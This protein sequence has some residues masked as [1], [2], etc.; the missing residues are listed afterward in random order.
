[1]EKQLIITELKVSS[2]KLV[3]QFMTLCKYFSHRIFVLA[4]GL[5]LL[6][7]WSDFL[8]KIL[9]HLL[10]DSQSELVTKYPNVAFGIHTITLTIV[11]LCLF[12]IM[13]TLFGEDFYPDTRMQ[14]FS[15]YRYVGNENGA[16]VQ[17]V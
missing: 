3:N 8:S 5:I 10:V 15:S 13:T 16:D 14:P 7:T 9:M 1:M 2:T 17:R 4:L 11:V 6:N 12:T